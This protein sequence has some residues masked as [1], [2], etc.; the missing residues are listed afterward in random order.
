MSADS[1][2]I[3]G[4][5]TKEQAAA[6]AFPESGTV[7]VSLDVYGRT[8]VHVTGC[9]TLKASVALLHHAINIVEKQLEG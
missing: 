7:V 1:G 8:S 5:R 9:V 4:R 2:D 3:K 6:V